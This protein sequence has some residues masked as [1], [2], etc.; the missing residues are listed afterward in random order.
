M[1]TVREEMR[2]GPWTEQEDMQLVC[3]VRLFG[4]RRWDF[5][6]QVSGLRGWE[7]QLRPQQDRKELP[8]Q[9][10]ELPPPWPQAWPYVTARGA[11]YY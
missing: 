5:I 6:A 7:L 4:D 8:P 9:V 3:T 11:P 2:K 10:G 1:V